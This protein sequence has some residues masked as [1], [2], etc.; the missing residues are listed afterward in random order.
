MYFDYKTFRIP[1]RL[2]YTGWLL[3]ITYSW[4]KYGL[5]GIGHSIL[6]IVAPIL[7]LFL[8]FF[9]KVLGAGDIKLFSVIG[10]FF[11]SHVILIIIFS[12]LITAV[13]GLLIVVSKLLRNLVNKGGCLG[14]SRMH[15]SVSI[16]LGVL[17][18]IVCNVYGILAVF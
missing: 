16:M 18:F 12:M 4:L 11:Y 6:W 7:I 15:F 5:W 14:F 8:L 2:N 1:N 10:S 13:Y 9:F 17:T 3:G